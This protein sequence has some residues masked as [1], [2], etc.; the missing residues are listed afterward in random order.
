[1]QSSELPSQME[2]ESQAH[3]SEMVLLEVSKFHTQATPN[4]VDK[5]RIQPR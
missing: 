1:M 3:L 4:E 2:L 5:V